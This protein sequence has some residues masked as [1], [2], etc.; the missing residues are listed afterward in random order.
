ML[1]GIS[2]RLQPSRGTVNFIWAQL[3]TGVNSFLTYHGKQPIRRLSIS[4]IKT[5]SVFPFLLCIPVRKQW[6]PGLKQ[7]RVWL[8]DSSLPI[9]S[10]LLPLVASLSSFTWC[11]VE[12]HAASPGNSLFN[13]CVPNTFCASGPMF[14]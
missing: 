2:L 14:E 11:C 10:T 3:Y 12:T 4:G 5:C 8:H 6:A 1:N 7:L 9:R 13:V